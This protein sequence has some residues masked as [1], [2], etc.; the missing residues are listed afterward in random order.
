MV[1]VAKLEEGKCHFHVYNDLN[2]QIS[3]EII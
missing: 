2:F 1:E 3:T